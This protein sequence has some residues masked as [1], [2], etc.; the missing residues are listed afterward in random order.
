M[1]DE[2]LRIAE[3]NQVSLRKSKVS[4]CVKIEGEGERVK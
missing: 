2:M 3:R 1:C 4:D